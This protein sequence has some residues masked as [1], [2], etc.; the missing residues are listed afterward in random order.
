MYLKNQPD[1]SGMEKTTQPHELKN[2][3]VNA[4]NQDASPSSSQ[5]G[6]TSPSVRH[7]AL[8]QGI[9][10]NNIK[11]TGPGGRILKEDLPN[12]THIATHSTKPSSPKTNEV[13]QK[14]PPSL[15]LQKKI[16]TISQDGPKKIESVQNILEERKI[17]K[18]LIPP[19]KEPAP[20]QAHLEKDK[21][22][23]ALHQTRLEKDKKEPAL[24]QTHL[25]KD[26]KE[27]QTK[28]QNLKSPAN[29]LK[30]QK[31]S[32]EPMSQLRQTIARRLVQSQHSTATLTT[33][34][35][36]D[37]SQIIKI[38]QQYKQAFQQRYE[39]NLGFMGF[40][41]KAVVEAL[42][43]YPK[44]NAFIK[45]QHIIYNHFYNIGIAVGTERG[46]IVPVI[47]NAQQLSLAEI[48]LD[49]RQYANK[50]RSG[51][52]TLNDLEG[53]TFTISNGGGLWL[54]AFHPYFESSSNR[55]FR[56]S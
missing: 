1:S 38:R 19:Q 36:V 2:F 21:K 29:I 40:F 4:L 24:H 12:Q 56:S 11:G 5:K 7:E 53:G 20:H 28:K 15:D 30:E 43:T 14:I 23:P 42:K 45:G 32:K 13:P 35:E 25:E 41:T 33:F 31:T 39:V 48:E 18:P 26:K 3:N 34:N 51:K 37:M 9:N 46:L 49:I 50:A 6:A 55:N 10:L 52:I 16:K 8:R 47:R 54:F 27:V 44:V 17:S 22:E